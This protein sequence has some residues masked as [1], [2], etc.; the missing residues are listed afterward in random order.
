MKLLNNLLVAIAATGMMGSVQAQTDLGMLS[1]TVQ[2]QTGFFA[3]GSFADIFNFSIGTE[4][5]AFLGSAAGLSSEGTPTI[6]AVSDLTFTLF[7][8]SNATGPIQGSVTSATGSVIDLSGALVEGAY[9][10][11]VSG[12]IADGAL[13]GGYALSVSAAPE[14]AEWMMLLAGLLLVV[15]VARRKT[16]LMAG[17]A[18]PA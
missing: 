11:R 8:G 13:G 18:A 16:R 5:Q 6:G 14:P 15:A 9:S 3:S 12:L 10:V 1:P 7:A 2:Q 17:G 4:N